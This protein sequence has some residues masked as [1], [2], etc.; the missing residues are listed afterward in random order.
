VLLE[1]PATANGEEARHLFRNPILSSPNAPILLE[2][3]H[4]QFHPAW[5]SFLSLFD[6]KDIEHAYAD[7]AMPS[8]FLPFDDIRFH[9]HLA[10]GTLMDMGT[11]NLSAIRGV[12][13][14]EP[15][16]VK[17]ATA[18]L[19]PQPYDQ[20]CDEA[21]DASYVFPNGGTANLHTDLLARVKYTKGGS[22]MS[23][24]FHG[25]GDF[26][27]KGIPSVCGVTLREK[28]GTEDEMNV[29]TQKTV[30]LN[31]FMGPH[32]GHSIDIHTTTTYRARD[33]KVVKTE[34]NTESKKVYVWPEGKVAGEEWWPT[35]R[36][37]LEAFVDRV[38]G[39]EG[40]GAWVEGEE[41]IKQMEC[42]DKTYE[43]AGMA[44]RPT[45][46]SLSGAGSL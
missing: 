23:W 4:Y 7:T 25:W 1:K 31:N 26:T 42:I 22:W 19:L 27:A 8:G 35:Y 45:S 30:T 18:R 12:F 38:R 46:K 21:M 43:K 28:N 2:A 6:P 37:M 15:S 16:S 36:Y 40:S 20:Q 33:G 13:G 34:K 10:G 5:H 9:Y 24:L 3:R 32:M 11:Y 39:R 14:T 17:S 44:I 41:S 29:T